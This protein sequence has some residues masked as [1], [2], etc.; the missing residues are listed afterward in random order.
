MVKNLIEDTNTFDIK[1]TPGYQKSLELAR[2]RF[3]LL[4]EEQLHQL[5]ESILMRGRLEDVQ[6]I[7][8]KD[9]ADKTAL[10]QRNAMSGTNMSVS[11]HYFQ[12]IDEGT[13]RASAINHCDTDHKHQHFVDLDIVNQHE[14]KR[15]LANIL[16][17]ELLPLGPEVFINRGHPSRLL[18]MADKPTGDMVLKAAIAEVGAQ[19]TLPLRNRIRDWVRKV[20]EDAQRAPSLNW[21]SD[22]IS[23]DTF[24]IT[25]PDK[26]TI[27]VGACFVQGQHKRIVVSCEKH[28]DYNIVVVN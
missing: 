16:N 4:N 17:P 23:K 28:E 26:D 2:T 7:D 18:M 6:Y 1:T 24:K 25:G 3:P 12:A 19:S 10:I 5:V 20:R 11:A 8:P 14:H 21:M 15:V 9:L 27:G 13:S 22:Q